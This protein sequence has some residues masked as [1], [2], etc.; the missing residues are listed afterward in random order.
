MAADIKTARAI[1]AS[2]VTLSGLCLAHCLALPL[3]ISVLPV[4]FQGLQSELFHQVL[5]LFAVPL[6][7][8]AGW[9]ARHSKNALAIQVLLAL[10]ATGLILGAFVEPLHDYETLLTVLG[11][12]LLSVGH[13]FR[14]FSHAPSQ[15]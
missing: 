5:V 3:L 2:A 15:S 10:G 9:G 7:M 8:L 13:I 14:W 1:D 12:L 11:A 4:T 6:A